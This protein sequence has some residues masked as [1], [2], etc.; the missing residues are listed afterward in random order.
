MLVRQGCDDVINRQCVYIYSFEQVY[1]FSDRS[2]RLGGKCFG[3]G[4]NLIG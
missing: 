3:A 1:T 2:R 4:V